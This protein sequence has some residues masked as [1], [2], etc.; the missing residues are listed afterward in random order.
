MRPLLTSDHPVSLSLYRLCYKHWW[1]YFNWAF[2]VFG[3]SASQ[4]IGCSWWKVL[5]PLNRPSPELILTICHRTQKVFYFFCNFCMLFIVGS[6]TQ[7]QRRLSI[8]HKW[9]ETLCLCICK[10]NSKKETRLN[11]FKFIEEWLTV[12]CYKHSLAISQ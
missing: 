1:K 7:F 10:L 2:Q 8:E 5:T 12:S 4:F 9:R 3:L 6:G 11:N